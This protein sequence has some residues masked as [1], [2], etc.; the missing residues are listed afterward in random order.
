MFANTYHPPGTAPATLVPLGDVQPVVTLLEYDAASLEE[1]RLERVED[2]A[3][4]RGNGK[5]RWIDIDGL[6]DVDVLNKLGEQFGL[7]PLALEDVLHAPQR[8]KVEEFEH[9]FF[10]V[11]QIPFSDGQGKVT[12]EQVSLFFGKDFLI[13]IQ[14]NPESDVFEPVRLRL[15]TGRGFA[16]TRGH[17]YLAYALL[18]CV[19]DHFFP[20]LEALGERIELL[21]DELLDRPTRES[22][23]QLH[24]I[25]RT[26]LQVRRNIW[27]VRE[28]FTTLS[29]DESG[30]VTHETTIFL[31]DCH[32]HTIRLMDVIENYRDL[33]ASM[34][35]IYLSAVGMRTN[36][37]MRVL[38]VV[39]TIFIPLTFIVGLYGMNFEFMPGLK[40]P[41]GFTVCVVGMVLLAA[42][43][44]AI[45]RHKKW[46]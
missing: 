21:E 13:S 16:R 32:D 8:P 43:M 20:V 44:L 30:L 2:L 7:H 10:I 26:L 40:S 4:S 35:D 11:A 19:V 1:R 37:V 45:F 18:D 17:D 28:L 9:H 24:E 6:A 41:W 14:E 12:F 42:G 22:L 27:P 33:T 25:K 3:V 29:R 36:E 38:T 31:R 5:M 39:S 23:V 15:R 34:M 46:I